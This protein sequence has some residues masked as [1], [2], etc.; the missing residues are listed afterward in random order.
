[1]A[2]A[3]DR[4]NIDVTQVGGVIVGQGAGSVLVGTTGLSSQA[5]NL[6]SSVGTT[7][8]GMSSAFASS[9]LVE[10]G[11][12]SG[13]ADADASGFTGATGPNAGAAAPAAGAAPGTGGIE[14]SVTSNSLAAFGAKFGSTYQAPLPAAGFT[15]TGLVALPVQF[16]MSAP[17]ITAPEQQTGGSVLTAGAL[18]IN[19]GGMLSGANSLTVTGAGASSANATSSGS[20]EG[21]SAGGTSSGTTAGNTLAAASTEDATDLS[22]IST[23]LNTTFSNSGTAYFDNGTPLPIASSF[24]ALPGSGAPVPV[25]PNV[26]TPEEATGVAAFDQA[27]TAIFGQL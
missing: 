25:D 26:V 7:T 18:T 19:A 1:M 23:G 14:T 11:E 13:Q 15:P 10:D 9:P 27:V 22:V 17:T 16:G 20:D 2:A 4:S 5:S 24:L 3:P 8:E 6:Q 12:A 21:G